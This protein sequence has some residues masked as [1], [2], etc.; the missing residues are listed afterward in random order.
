MTHRLPFAIC[1]LLALV[2]AAATASPA[3]GAT[4]AADPAARELTALDGAIVW[5][6]ETASGRQMLMQ[7]RGGAVAAV[8]GAPSAR[9]YRSVDLGRDRRGRL[10]LTYLRCDRPSRC[11][12]R[13][14]DLAGGRAGV[15]GLAVPGCRLATAPALWLDRA[16]YGLE[17]RTGGGRDSLRSGLYVKRGTAAP[18]RIQRPAEAARF[19]VSLVT[20]VD[21]RGERV[22][23]VLSDVYSYAYSARFDGS[24]LRSMRVAS[25]EGESDEQAAGLA[26]GGGDALWSLTTSLHVGDPLQ[27]VIN[28][29]RGRCRAIQVL[30]G[31]DEERYPA[32]DLALDLDGRRVLLIVPGTG[33]VTH[34]F[35]P[36]RTC[37]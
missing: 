12:A 13:R 24:G 34:A 37:V 6:T 4:L 10:V 23:A 25:S 5:V 11:V 15:P 2:A 3:A 18:R 14:D 32:T 17:C 22:A 21:L 33:I 19:G 20:S 27:T 16:A 26:L 9:F 8:R 28:R 1:A 35:A 36:G 31:V 7:R 30:T 29:R